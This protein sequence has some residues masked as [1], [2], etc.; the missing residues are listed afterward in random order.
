MAPFG[1]LQIGCHNFVL[2]SEDDLCSVF[3]FEALILIC[4]R[5]S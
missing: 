1:I 3:Q 2:N 5:W 4:R